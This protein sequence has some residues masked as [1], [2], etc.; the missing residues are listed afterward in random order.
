VAASLGA[1]LVIA[2]A[3]G[4]EQGGEG[5][6]EGAGIRM[7]VEPAMAFGADTTHL[8]NQQRAAEQVGPI[9]L[10]LVRTSLSDGRERR[11]WPEGRHLPS[12]QI[13]AG[14]QGLGDCLDATR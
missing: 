13:L 9:R 11:G 8:P 12:V 14:Q 10:A 7:R 1:N 4:P 3:L 5:V 6:D 2:A